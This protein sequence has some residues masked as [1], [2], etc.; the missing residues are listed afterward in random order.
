MKG[1]AVTSGVEM[2]CEPEALLRLTQEFM[3]T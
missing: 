2:K 1:N 3:Q